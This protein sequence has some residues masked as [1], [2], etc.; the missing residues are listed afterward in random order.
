MCSFVVKIEYYRL[1][2]LRL[3][4]GNFVCDTCNKCYKYKINLKQHMEEKH[5]QH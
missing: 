3:E 1:E 4:M 2:D 5:I